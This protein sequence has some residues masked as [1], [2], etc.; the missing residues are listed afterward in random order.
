MRIKSAIIYPIILLA[1]SIFL[2]NCGMFDKTAGPEERAAALRTR[3]HWEEG[4]PPMISAHRGSP[5]PGYPENSMAAFRRSYELGAEIIE[6][7]VRSSA[8]GFLV[9]MH[10]EDISRTTDGNGRVS[11]YKL[12]ELLQFFLLDTENDPTPHRIPLL[13]EVLSWAVANDVILT[14]DLKAVEP[15]HLLTVIREHEAE[16]NVIVIVYNFEDMMRWHGLAPELMISA[17]AGSFKSLQ[18]LFTYAIPKNRLVVFTGV[19]EP[20]NAIYDMLHQNGIYAILGTMHNLDNK[21]AKQ[22]VRVYQNLYRNGAD[23]LSTDRVEL[24]SRAIRD[25]KKY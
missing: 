4:S 18:T 19:G 5:A 9:L 2:N 12:R 14:L 22:G 10:D 11:T 16:G 17:S 23:I 25:M 21:A 3:M 20:K 6:C 7:D 8:D 24:V 13:G 15:T 1:G